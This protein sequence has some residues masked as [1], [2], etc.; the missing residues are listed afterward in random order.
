M[1]EE[2]KQKFRIRRDLL[3]ILGLLILSALLWLAL[4]LMPRG[5][6]AVVTVDGAQFGRYPLS[7]DRQVVIPGYDGVENL[8]VIAEG[9]AR[10]TE[11]D[12]PDKLC[13]GFG[14]ISRQHE[15]IVCL[16]HRVVI[17]IEGGEES[18]VDLP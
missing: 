7:R 14:A 12:C 11:A 17:T 8:L 9:A 18:G 3:L 10:V 4:G 2:G 5:G 13:I 15:S 16:P 1:T 6:V